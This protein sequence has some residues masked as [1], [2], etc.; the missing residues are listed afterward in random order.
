MSRN[1]AAVKHQRA[2]QWSRVSWICLGVFA[3]VVA[4]AMTRPV[5]LATTVTSRD[6]VAPADAVEGRLLGEPVQVGEAAR[7]VGEAAS[8]I[9][10]A[11][12]AEPLEQPEPAAEIASDRAAATV[13]PA[14]VASAQAELPTTTMASTTTISSPATTA[15]AVTP[16]VPQSVGEASV[17]SADTEPAAEVVAQGT[18]DAVAEPTA[19]TETTVVSEQ[20]ASEPEPSVREPEEQAD[21]V[22]VSPT[23]EL[24]VS[25]SGVD[26]K[27][28]GSRGRPLRTP[29]FAIDQ[30]EP[31][32]TIN[33]LP[34]RYESVV[35]QNVTDLSV[36]APD[37]GVTVSSGSYDEGVAILIEGSSRVSV[38]N[39]KTENSLWGVRVLGSSDVVVLQNTILD[40]GQEAIHVGERSSAVRLEGNRIDTTGQR[41]GSNDV[42]DFADFGEGIYL[43]SA[44]SLPDGRDDVVSDVQIIGNHISNTTAE[45]IELKAPVR[46]VVIR[47][48]IVHDI[49]VDS[50]GAISVGVGVHT[51]DADA[52]IEEN[53]IWN[54]TTRSKWSDGIGI[55]LSSSATVR[56]NVILSTEH[57]GIL[58][59]EDIRPVDGAVTIHGNLVHSTGDQEVVDRSDG[60]GAKVRIAD[61]I[62]GSE[63]RELLAEYGQSIDRPSGT[64]LLRLLDALPS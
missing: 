47:N 17:A 9:G 8:P 57:Y 4:T 64:G 11:P 36:T 40:T 25:P 58:L 33:L 62:R 45:A 37:G 20:V 60:T 3:V 52:V 5:D 19:V 2:A 39:L 42:R 54:V 30:A 55:R 59:D 41:S 27:N 63:A 31:G 34:G 22:E 49:E 32:D 12:T 7:T 50:G 21:T 15:E 56:N 28:G 16:S 44:G 35:L 18:A 51:Y 24:W 43:G 26:R 48:N 29:A 6:V 13:T 38:S 46:D 53:V 61:T 14:V 10:I 23:D 1:W